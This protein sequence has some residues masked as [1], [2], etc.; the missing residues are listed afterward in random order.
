M[1]IVP[2]INSAPLPGVRVGGAAPDAAFGGGVGNATLGLNPGLSAVHG[3]AARIAQEETDKADQVQRTDNRSRIMEVTTGLLFGPDGV[4]TKQGKDAFTA[5][6]DARKRYF[7]AVGQI[8]AGLSDRQRDAFD[9]DASN[10]WNQINEQVQSHVASQRQKYDVQTTSAA[11]EN[12][13]NLA[14]QSYDKPDIVESLIT[15][16]RE[17]TKAFGA[18]NGWSEDQIK[19]MADKRTSDT[20]VGIVSRMLDDGNDLAASKYYDEHRDQIDGVAQ[21]KIEKALEI[22]SRQGEALRITNRILATKENGVPITATAALAQAEAVVDP[23]VRNEAIKEVTAHFGEADRAQRIDRENARARVLQSLRANNG[24]LNEASSDWQLINGYP[25]G[26]H[27][28]VEQHQ[29]LHPPPDRGDPDKYFSYLAMAHTSDAT[30]A[31]L[32]GMSV[33]DI[34]D[35][36]TMSP[37]QKT[38]V[39]NLIV[40]EQHKDLSAITHDAT[41]AEREAKALEK[42]VKKARDEKDQQTID[43]NAPAMYAAQQRATVLRGQMLSAKRA[44]RFIGTPAATPGAIASPSDSPPAPTSGDIDLRNPLGLQPLK[45]ITPEMLRD[46]GTHGAGYAEYLRKSGYAVPAIL[47]TTLKP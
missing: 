17:D 24:R 20:R 27:V 34:N 25:E 19:E 11:V 23:R 38:S 37:G 7:D 45:P 29:I 16:V 14:L 31:A 44:S 35:D 30:R 13:Q 36:A 46:I 42:I 40:S 9:T 32:L 8:R 12:A 28:L 1:P 15:G 3:E 6:E 33:K 43:D 2:R 22:G 39:L 18:R 4:L 21:G 41:E 5:P 26:E 47:P 10:Q